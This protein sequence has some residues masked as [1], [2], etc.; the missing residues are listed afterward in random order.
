MTINGGHLVAMF[1]LGAACDPT[2]GLPSAGGGYTM[3]A[4]APDSIETP[5]S[6]EAQGVAHDDAS[7]YLSDRWTIYRY[8]ADADLAGD[9]YDDSIGLPRGCQHFGDIDVVDGTL[10]AALE[11][12]DAGLPLRVYLYDAATLEV[13]AWGIIPAKVQ[14]HAPWVAI[15]PHDGNLYSSNDDGDVITVYAPP[16]GKGEPLTVVRRIVLDR[17]YRGIQ[18]ATFSEDGRYFYLVSNDVAHRAD[19]GVHVFTLDGP[20]ARHVGAIPAPG[21]YP[22]GGMELE[23]ITIWDR[24]ELGD[25]HWVILDNDL[26]SDADDVT[27]QHARATGWAE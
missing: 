27:M 12:C 1:F 4:S 5:W 13:E 17:L 14:A 2:M 16:R 19:A 9:G 10:A 18:G 3:V 8:A 15:G 22:G 23:G 25:V 6:T 24:G 21:R 26:P 11:D 20:E 7:W